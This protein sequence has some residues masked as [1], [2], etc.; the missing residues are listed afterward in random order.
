MDYFVLFLFYFFGRGGW[1]QIRKKIPAQLL[2]KKYK[3]CIA[4]QREKKYCKLVPKKVF[5]QKTK[6]PPPEKYNMFSMILSN[7]KF[8]FVVNYSLIRKILSSFQ[9][10]K[11]QSK[12]QS[13]LQSK[14]QSRVQSSFSIW[15][16]MA[17]E[18]WLH[19]LV[20]L[21]CDFLCFASA[22]RPELT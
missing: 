22:R 15:P 1:G 20:D 14:V 3:S 7:L 11:S 12:V 5:M 6:S 17:A 8:L 13:R 16:A 19:I 4:A 9:V 10:N 18:R 2:Q 21:A